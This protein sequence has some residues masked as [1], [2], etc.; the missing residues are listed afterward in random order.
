MQVG[1]AGGTAQAGETVCAGSMSSL[2]GGIWFSKNQP[3]R[4]IE[5]VVSEKLNPMYSTR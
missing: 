4:E 5:Q 2:I 1:G 3:E